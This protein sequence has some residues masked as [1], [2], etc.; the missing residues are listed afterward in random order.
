MCLTIQEIT[1][2]GP[3]E[4]D[5]FFAV[6]DDSP[7]IP[8]SKDEIDKLLAAALNTAF[9]FCRLGSARLG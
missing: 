3:G 5:A 2:L 6:G 4:G 9:R 8:A 1:H 7:A